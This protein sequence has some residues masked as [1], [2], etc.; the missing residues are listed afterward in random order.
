VLLAL[1]C[2]LLVIT[3]PEGVCLVALLFLFRNTAGR[4]ILDW[5]IACIGA[6]F[7][8]ILSAAVNWMTGHHLTPLTMQGRNGVLPTT[9]WIGL[10]GQFIGHTFARFLSVWSITLPQ[11]LLHG[12][13]LLLGLP[14]AVVTV[15]L[16]SLAV[17]GLS[18]RHAHRVIL[19]CA[20]GGFIE[21]LYF[22][23]L[24]SPGHGGRYIAVPVMLFLPLIFYGL[25]QALRLTPLRENAGWGAVAVFAAITAVL[26]LTAWRSAA[27]ADI[28][29][30][31][32]E[33][34]VMASWIESNLPPSV[35]ADRQIAIFDIGRMGYAMHGNLIDLGGLVDY[36]FQSYLKTAHTAEYLQ[37]HG[38]K[39][40]VLA[41]SSDLYNVG[42]FSSL[43]LDNA[44]GV[45]LSL[46]H[47]VCADKAVAALA[48][49]SSE[50]AMPCQ[51][52]YAVHY[53][54]VAAE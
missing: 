18:S 22:F 48:F 1:L 3:R 5:L 7:A 11:H 36:R 40:V 17:R 47:N 30:I 26:S 4:S 35:I 8:G 49:T 33:H 25:H 19:F 16:V 31:N 37:Q 9:S 32:T 21:V 53:D 43:A 6:F 13:G 28:E 2:F 39:Y 34:G 27:T 42:F 14:V 24:P 54:S 29:Q 38:V 12:R 10:R 51:R 41:G 15:A 23:M 44:H 50:T 45:D 20:W 52:L 46:I